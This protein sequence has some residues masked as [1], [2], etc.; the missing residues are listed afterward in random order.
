MFS[1]TPGVAKVAH[2]FGQDGLAI[3]AELG[4]DRQAVQGM[5]D[6]GVLVT[7]AVPGRPQ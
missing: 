3:L 4:F 7:P 2:L 1:L 5:I 6:G